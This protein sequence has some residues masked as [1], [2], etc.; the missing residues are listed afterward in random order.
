[1]KK[2]KEKFTEKMFA[3]ALAEAAESKGLTDKLKSL[4]KK[5]SAAIV[6]GLSEKEFPK[7]TKIDLSFKFPLGMDVPVYWQ[8]LP[9]NVYGWYVPPKHKER[10]VEGPAILISRSMF[11]RLE[12]DKNDTNAL[13]TIFHEFGHHWQDTQYDV[14]GTMNLNEPDLVKRY[15]NYTSK[16]RIINQH[17]K[18]LVANFY[19]NEPWAEEVAKKLHRLVKRNVFEY[20]VQDKLI[21]IE[22]TRLGYVGREIEE[23]VVKKAVIASMAEDIASKCN[24]SDEEDKG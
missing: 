2:I 21:I 8:I 10:G 3:E 15:T 16:E 11:K 23:D 24:G 19:K 13:L 18:M 17:A 5:A 12:K 14:L 22:K 7:A 9:K 6:E 4:I 20:K 1:M